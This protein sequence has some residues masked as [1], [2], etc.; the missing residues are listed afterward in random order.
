MNTP[1]RTV[2]FEDFIVRWTRGGGVSAVRR[3]GEEGEKEEASEEQD[4]LDQ[5]SVVM[6]EG[7]EPG[8]T[9]PP[10]SYW[11]RR[12]CVIAPRPPSPAMN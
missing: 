1:V 10:C 11:A 4:V 8:C 2:I 6:G 3:V 9:A 5:E 12:P 7:E